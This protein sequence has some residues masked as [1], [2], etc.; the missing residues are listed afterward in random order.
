[1]RRDEYN[2]GCETHKP[3]AQVWYLR[4]E[5][6]KDGNYAWPHILSEGLAEGATA[7]QLLTVHRSSVG[8]CVG[9]QV[10]DS[11]PLVRVGAAY[12]LLTVPRSSVGRYV[13]TQVD[14]LRPLVRVVAAY[15][16]LEARTGTSRKGFVSQSRKKKPFK[17][18]RLARHSKSPNPIAMEKSLEDMCIRAGFRVGKWTCG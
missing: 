3:H 8:R 10:D 5:D 17:Q 11:R 14:D 9:A 13:G 16:L 1:M 18:C 12:Q 4:Q 15:Q 2:S 7:Y 6:H